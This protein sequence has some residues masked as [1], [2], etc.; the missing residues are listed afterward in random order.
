M[1]NG[2]CSVRV[3]VR[4]AGSRAQRAPR[5]PSHSSLRNWFRWRLAKLRPDPATRHSL[6]SRLLG[7]VPAQRLVDLIGFA[8]WAGRR[9]TTY[10]VFV[11]RNS[12]NVVRRLCSFRLNQQAGRRESSH[13]TGG[14]RHT[15]SSP[16]ALTCRPYLYVLNSPALY[17][18]QYS[19]RS[20][21]TLGESNTRPRI[22]GKAIDRI[23]MSE[24]SSTF[25]RFTIAPSTTQPT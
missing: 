4:V 15:C 24:K 25:P 13:L 18:R 6:D 14:A 17:R 2:T 9:L 23:I 10:D 20:R 19:I 1:W 22:L 16:R 7:V 11:S 5:R 21:R 3:R 8:R 12:L